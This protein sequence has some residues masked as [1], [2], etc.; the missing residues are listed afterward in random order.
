MTKDI[1]RDFVI[2]VIEE[3]LLGMTSS[4]LPECVLCIA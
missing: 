3:E 2:E 1:R 4:S